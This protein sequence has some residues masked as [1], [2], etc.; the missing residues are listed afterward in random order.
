MRLTLTGIFSPTVTP[1]QSITSESFHNLITNFCQGGVCAP[2]TNG[3][4]NVRSAA[5]DPGPK[6]LLITG[7]LGPTVCAASVLHAL[8]YAIKNDTV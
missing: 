4:S 6:P 2:P 5:Q 1:S 7:F 3:A 8:I